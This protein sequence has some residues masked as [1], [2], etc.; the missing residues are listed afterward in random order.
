V[1]N[2]G[3]SGPARGGEATYHLE[4]CLYPDEAGDLGVR[5]LLLLGHV[6]RVLGRL[7]AGAVRGSSRKDGRRPLLG[8]HNGSRSN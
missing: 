1:S 5:R 8:W 4:G 6:G 3:R 7:G 2:A